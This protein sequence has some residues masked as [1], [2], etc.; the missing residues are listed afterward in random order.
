MSKIKTTKRVGNFGMLFNILKFEEPK[1]RPS[2]KAH[3]PEKPEKLP[4]RIKKNRYKNIGSFKGDAEKARQAKIEAFTR[5]YKVGDIIFSPI[6]RHCKILKMNDKTVAV[7][8]VD[9]HGHQT[10]MSKQ[11]RGGAGVRPLLVEKYLFTV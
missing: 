1:K 4:P 11:I 3:V 9:E 10:E 7:M 5:K 6:Y 8:Q 2:K